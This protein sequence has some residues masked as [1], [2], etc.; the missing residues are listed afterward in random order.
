[1]TSARFRRPVFALVTLL[2]F[3]GGAELWAGRTQTVFPM[4]G[5]ADNPSV[6]LTGHPTRVWGL[7]EGER[8]NLDTVA[9]VNALGLRGDV[10][11]MPRP[12]NEER[13]VILGDSTFFGF[14]V[15]DQHTMASVLEGQLVGATTINGGI[16]GYSTAQ[17]LR[18][19][20]EVIWD[21][22][23]T[24]L[25]VAN[26]W[27][28]TSFEPY[29]DKDLLATQDV[30]NSRILAHS[31]FMRWL[32]T[33]LSGL[34]A[35]DRSRI[36]TWVRGNELPPATQR[37]VTLGD[38]AAN[39]DTIIRQAAARGVGV[40]LLTP[41]S[42]LEVMGTV[43]PPHQWDAFRDMQAAVSAHHG[44]PHAVATPVFAAAYKETKDIG[45]L[46]LD[47]LHPSVRG[48]AMLATL[49]RDTLNEAGWPEKRLLGTKIAFAAADVV[50]ATPNHLQGPPD[51]NSSPTQNL[52]MDPARSQA[53]SGPPPTSAPA[54]LHISIQ[55]GAAPYSLKVIHA[56]NIVASARVPEARS[57]SLRVPDGEVR[58]QITD[59]RGVIQEQTGKAGNALIGIIFP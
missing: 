48:Q 15:A 41:P 12:A 45:S 40:M 39:L 32:A 57:L 19:L 10:P 24:L 44:V 46:F 8:Q 5:A 22:D 30:S 51:G 1:M 50:D 2:I 55:G 26:F 43:D 3:F 13:I 20:D 11:Q 9:T 33:A 56:G 37:R 18:L 17:T 59:A 21:L 27:S 29:R 7:T 52:F 36:V 42:H 54:Q 38:Y 6:V 28:D 16:P 4:W 25:V 49:V 35:P 34:R 14:G 23:P 47:D 31:A 58:V 53:A